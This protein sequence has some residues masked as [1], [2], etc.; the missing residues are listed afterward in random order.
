MK[1]DNTLYFEISDVIALVIIQENFRIGATDNKVKM[2]FINITQKLEKF[3]FFKLCRSLFHSD[4]LA[5]GS[6][7]SVKFMIEFCEWRTEQ[8]D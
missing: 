1:L 8:K 3:L 4:L 2:I 7:I 5:Q 6:H